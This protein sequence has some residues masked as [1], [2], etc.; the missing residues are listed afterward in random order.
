MAALK[1]ISELDAAIA[2]IDGAWAVP[3]L[4]MIVGGVDP[5]GLR[6]LNFGMMAA[7]FPGST[8]QPGASDRMS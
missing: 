8:T 7:A 1:N 5:L 2:G 6:Q 3:P 4:P